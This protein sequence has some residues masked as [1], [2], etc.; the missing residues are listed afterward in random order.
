MVGFSGNERKI[1]EA[2]LS[3]VRSRLVLVLGV[4]AF[5]LMST[6]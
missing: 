2:A 5:S 1:G 3:G 4:G 6:R